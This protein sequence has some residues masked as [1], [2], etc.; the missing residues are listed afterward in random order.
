WVQ[1]F[2]HDHI[3]IYTQP[4]SFDEWMILI[5]NYLLAEYRAAQLIDVFFHFHRYD[6]NRNTIFIY[7]GDKNY[8]DKDEADF[9]IYLEYN[10]ESGT[11]TWLR[12][13]GRK[14]TEKK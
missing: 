7:Y 10:H 8:G 11:N 9:V 2:K 4:K 5:N 3:P 14:I 13:S 1:K 6:N 12:E